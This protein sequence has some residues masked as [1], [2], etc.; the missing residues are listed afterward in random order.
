MKKFFGNFSL[1][2]YCQIVHEKIFFFSIKNREKILK[3]CIYFPIYQINCNTYLIEQLTTSHRCFFQIFVFFFSIKM[4]SNLLKYLFFFS[5]CKKNVSC[6]F[7]HTPFLTSVYSFFFMFP[8]IFNSKDLDG[9]SFKNQFSN[10]F[11]KPSIF[12]C[13]AK[14]VLKYLKLR[15]QSLK[16]LHIVLTGTSNIIG[17][18]LVREFLREGA[19]VSVF[20]E[21]SS[22]LCQCLLQADIFVSAFS[23]FSL[24]GDCFLYKKQLV[25]IDIA[26]IKKNNRVNGNFSL[27]LKYLKYS[28]SVTPIPGGIGPLTMSY[29]LRNAFIFL[30]KLN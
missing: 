15:K 18:P 3:L 11:F 22:K 8:N 23:N 17:I 7:S 2:C 5:N 1:C 20:K 24:F 29:F 30:H 28:I 26:F 4:S 13:T 25:L 10:F 12:S 9:V 6:F 14:S 19:C 16:G 27:C 21:I